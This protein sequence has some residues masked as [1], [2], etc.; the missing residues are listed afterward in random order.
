MCSWRP[1][2]LVTHEDHMENKGIVPYAEMTVTPESECRLNWDGNRIA[3]I[4]QHGR[5][6]PYDWMENIHDSCFW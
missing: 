2:Y 4:T 3:A 5:A 1:V 6:L